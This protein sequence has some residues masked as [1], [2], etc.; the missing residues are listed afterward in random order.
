MMRFRIGNGFDAHKI[1]KG[2]G[3]TLGGIF[4][5]CDYSLIAHSD[6]DIISHT[7]CDALLGAANLGDIGVHFPN[8]KKFENISG[9]EMI[10]SVLDK[11]QKQNYEISNIDITYIGEVPRLNSHKR[12]IINC[13]SKFLKVDEEKIS[14]KATT[15]DQLGFMGK[16]EGVACLANVLIYKNN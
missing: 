1:K 4:I 16:K 5:P 2:N 9:K 12:E 8:T 11:L 15:T 13:L 10:E 14:C 3:V 6:G 7:V